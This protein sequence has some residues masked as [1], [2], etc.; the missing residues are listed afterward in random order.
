MGYFLYYEKEGL[1]VVK[2]RSIEPDRKE[3]WFETPLGASWEISE[4]E[5]EDI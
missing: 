5:T 1:E 4:M 2:R 3:V